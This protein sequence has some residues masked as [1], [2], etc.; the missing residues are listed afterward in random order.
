MR[1]YL[2]YAVKVLGKNE[3]AEAR[4]SERR[5]RFC[6]L[7]SEQEAVDRAKEFKKEESSTCQSL[8]REFIMG[9]LVAVEN[10]K[11]RELRMG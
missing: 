1:Y 5:I 10:G 6:G 11:V 4:V 7:L 3:G 9:S 8:G 2:F